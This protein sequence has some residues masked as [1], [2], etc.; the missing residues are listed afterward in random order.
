V[1]LVSEI[2]L[3]MVFIDGIV[4]VILPGK[5]SKKEEMMEKNFNFDSDSQ[6]TTPQLLLN[7][8]Y[9]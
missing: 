2:G 5:V 6:K 7:I 3:G 9:V 8:I 4:H 1:A